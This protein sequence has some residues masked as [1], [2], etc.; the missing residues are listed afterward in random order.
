MGASTFRTSHEP[1]GEVRVAK[2]PPPS[3]L[4]VVTVQ[5]SK[6]SFGKSYS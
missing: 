3:L 5:V 2:A 4:H 1:G 6:L